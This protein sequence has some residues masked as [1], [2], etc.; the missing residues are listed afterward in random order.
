MAVNS[1]CS[2]G[3]IEMDT[4]R[5]VIVEVIVRTERFDRSFDVI[6][7]TSKRTFYITCC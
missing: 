5:M 3:R 7:H 6:F 4:F 1:D 2:E